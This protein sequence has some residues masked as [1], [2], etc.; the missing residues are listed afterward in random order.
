[1]LK[2]KIIWEFSIKQEI[3]QRKE[4]FSLN[5]MIDPIS[6]FVYYIINLYTN[7]RKYNRKCLYPLLN[8]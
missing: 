7:F 8:I 6:L 3:L 4:S 5:R 1:M 2:I